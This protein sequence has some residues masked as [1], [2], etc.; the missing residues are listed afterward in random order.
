MY[1]RVLGKVHTW[2]GSEKAWPNWSSMKGHN[3]ATDQQLSEDVRIIVDVVSNGQLCA[4]VRRLGLV[5][6]GKRLGSLYDV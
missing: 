2:F 1:A 4:V 6:H 3:G 5:V